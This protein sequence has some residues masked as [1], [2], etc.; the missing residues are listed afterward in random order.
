MAPY[1]F[2]FP[3][4][5]SGPADFLT[6]MVLLLPN[7]LVS[8][9][10]PIPLSQD[11]EREYLIVVEGPTPRSLH[12]P[13]L[14][15]QLEA[16]GSLV[17]DPDNLPDADN[18]PLSQCCA[19]MVQELLLSL[20]FPYHS[21]GPEDL[22]LVGKHPMAAGGSANIWEGTH[23]GRKVVLKSYRCYRVSFDIAQVIAVHDNYCSVRRAHD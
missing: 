11:E 14:S 21:L 15:S 4:S 5:R 1:T 2:D 9:L 13:P 22:K 6:A 17:P 23:E 3:A 7:H 8:Y 19:Q 12:R 16:G 18:L 20:P 10:C